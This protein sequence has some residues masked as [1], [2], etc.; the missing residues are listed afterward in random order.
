MT[1]PF[2]AVDALAALCY[3][4]VMPSEYTQAGK[5]KFLPIEMRKI[6]VLLSLVSVWTVKAGQTNLTYVKDILPIVMTK[7]IACL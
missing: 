7:C 6:A 3:H 4:G 1:D 2:Y 5:S